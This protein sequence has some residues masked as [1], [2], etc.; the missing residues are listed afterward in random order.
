MPSQHRPYTTIR[1]LSLA[2][3]FLLLVWP[4]ATTVYPVV[5]TSFAASVPASS[6]PHSAVAL[7]HSP[8]DAAQ[9]SAAGE[10]TLLS[11]S[12]QTDKVQ[13]SRINTSQSVEQVELGWYHTCALIMSG[14]V[15][16]WG[17]NTDG[18]LG[19]GTNIGQ[20]TPVD[21]SGL[22]TGVLSIAAASGSSC[23][24]TLVA[25][26][27]CWGSNGDGQLGDNTT[28]NRN[29]PV[30]VIG[31]ASGVLQVVRGDSHT[32]ALLT[33]GQVECW[34]WND[35][36]QLG[37]GTTTER[38]T[39]V[40]VSNLSDVKSIAAGREHTCAV[41][42]SGGAK[43][44]GGGYYG[45]L[46]T[47][48]DADQ[49]TPVD[50]SGL[51]VGVTQIDAG[52]W[53]TCALVNGGV[54][55]WGRNNH[56]EVGDGTTTD[57]YTPTDV[58]GLT[59][60]MLMVAAG[61]EHTCA[62]TSGGG[63]K[64]WG[65]GGWG[66][67]GNGA[68]NDS[69]YPVDVYM[70]SSGTTSVSTGGGGYLAEHT[71]A[72]TQV[73][74]LKCWGNNSW[75]QLGDGT[76]NNSN[77][78]VDVSGLTGV[79]P[80][81]TLSITVSP[82]GAGTITPNIPGDCN[83]GAGYTD[84]TTVILTANPN[85]GYNFT[86]WS[87]DV[88]STTNPLTVTVT[89][90]KAIVANFATP[91]ATPTAPTATSTP[92]PTDSP[93]PTNTRIQT[94]TPTST[95]TVTPTITPTPTDTATPT[96]T[97]TATATATP[98]GTAPPTDTSTPTATS[99]ATP[100]KTPAPTATPTNNSQSCIQPPDG[101]V[102]WWRG[103]GDAIDSKG[104]N[105]GVLVNGVNFAPGMVGQGFQF[106]GGGDYVTVPDATS[107]NPTTYSVEGW[108]Y[109]TTPVGDW[110]TIL[111]KGSNYNES[112]KLQFDSTRMFVLEVVNVGGNRTSLDTGA[113]SILLN[114]WLH[115]AGTYDGN[116]ASLYMNGS[117]VS[118]VNING[119]L[120]SNS[121]PL[122][123]GGGD[124]GILSFS[125]LIDEVSIYNRALTNSEIQGIYNAGSSGKCTTIPTNTPTPTATTTATPT[126]TPTPTATSTATPTDTP[127]PTVTSTTT[128]TDTATPTPTYTAT[129][130]PTDTATTTPTTTS[131]ATP[132][133]TPTPTTT[134]T[135]TPTPT[136]TNTATPTDTPT[137]TATP[138]ATST[139]TPTNTS[140]PTDT[141]TAT[142]TPTPTET[143]TNTPTDTPTATA[144]ETAT[145][146][147]T[148]TDTA[149]P[150]PT[151]TATATP[152]DTATATPTTTS[153]ATP[154]D[155]PTPTTTPTDTPTPTA[156]N[157][158]TPT[159]TP[160]P[161]ATP[162]ATS[163]ATP[164]NTSTPTDTPTA[165][166]T[167]T[168][169]STATPTDTPTATSTATP[170]VTPTTTS[171]ATPTVT[172]TAT[173][174]LPPQHL[175]VS[176]LRTNGPGG[177]ADE[178]VELFNPATTVFDI[179]GWL[180]RTSTS[181]GITS[182]VLTI[183]SGT[184]LAPGQHFLAA[185]NGFGGTVVP[186]VR[187]SANIGDFAGIALFMADGLTIVDQVGMSV[188]TTYKE[189]TNLAVLQG[190]LDQSYER[191]GG[192]CTDTNNNA[193]DYAVQAPSAPQNLASA[194]TPCL[195]PTPTATPTATSTATPPPHPDLTVDSLAVIP[196]TPV[197]GQPMTI[198]A[199]IH[200]QGNADVVVP[201]FNGLYVDKAAVGVPDAQS[202]TLSLAAGLTTTT[203]FSLTLTSGAHVLS[204]LTDWAGSIS[205]S[206]ES[207]NA[208]VLIV[209]VVAS[210]PLDASFTAA[211]TT[212][213]A[214]LTVY[215]TN[216]STGTYTD[217]L[218][219]FGD[220]MTSTLTNTV[221]VYDTPGT[222]TVTLTISDSAGSASLTQI[223]YI[224]AK[225]EYW[226]YLPLVER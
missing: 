88:I 129:A 124:P 174:T 6:A 41:T 3:C 116:T 102:S 162:T 215:F 176:E 225:Q 40:L 187:F 21:V 189:G 89:S 165:T 214:P 74:G 135:D 78:P 223:G 69:A 155:T 221:H 134:P 113:N 173:P 25:A 30:D 49:H 166:A 192:E 117:L 4:Q 150:T 51:T 111:T 55:C 97:A 81:Y 16:C 204:V 185:N 195:A 132:T 14:G 212:G 128:P 198:S 45:R 15:K 127:T 126:D 10:L 24:A 18:Q 91:T 199:V 120:Q 95:G 184:T 112:Y 178:F 205:E 182:T 50:V 142:S 169:T 151:Y 115:L 224:V 61:W 46:G 86:D 179:G 206:D 59:S 33:T 191:K 75:G 196:A 98:T 203:T 47:G 17:D 73:G 170:T 28:I 42:N 186:D 77:T 160:T 22:S 58:N 101:L 7:P 82:A 136:A 137:P 163:T 26:V 5:P 27:K 156:T 158:A 180:I 56:G 60:N 190:N 153:T 121:S 131:T 93:T 31:L 76:T 140:T 213:F 193:T 72:R 201:F 118:T 183:A 34:G 164:T 99:T 104:S 80:C 138:T 194:L 11:V 130:T 119:T 210:T 67:L 43:C 114:T 181:T 19:D 52:A 209:T 62:L 147:A 149:T 100:T 108:I 161:T 103:E 188:G 94:A 1:R 122:V 8:P 168:A 141:P 35:F 167:E 79:P 70:L 154:T 144:T 177:S 216:T 133:D 23:A 226:L 145:S 53:H 63:I 96:A 159:D 44:W 29:T 157:T 217:T 107:L 146:T 218:W 208:G 32:C 2:V 211:P 197:A 123:I 39:P 84:G 202:F 110:R 12:S 139:A 64:C 9:V 36:G 66:Q 222:Y 219:S 172:P 37:D 106:S 54:K 87:G 175:V 65:S 20:I 13:L 85:T 171:T 105:N 125:G 68:N 90:D 109:A 92:T 200:N 71:C 207:N 83:N 148:P 220:G 152:T 57:R 38:H 143:A 48:N